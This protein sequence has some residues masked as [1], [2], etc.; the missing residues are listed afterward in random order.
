MLYKS[1]FDFKL[2]PCFY[3]TKFIEGFYAFLHAVSSTVIFR[4]RN[5]L[6]VLSFLSIIVVSVPRSALFSSGPDLEG[7]DLMMESCPPAK[8]IILQQRT[9]SLNAAADHNHQQQRPSR[10]IEEIA[11]SILCPP[12]GLGGSYMD[13]SASL[14]T[15]LLKSTFNQQNNL[16]LVAFLLTLYIFFRRKATTIDCFVRQSA[17]TVGLLATSGLFFVV[18]EAYGI[19]FIIFS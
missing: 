16:R 4:W 17:M 7:G 10:L 9:C 12:R 8:P 6:K 2:W 18:N 11:G 5:S 3:S 1:C 13:A 15:S 14:S 19:F